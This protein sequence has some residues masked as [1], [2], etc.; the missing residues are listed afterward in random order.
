MDKSLKDIKLKDL[1]FVILYGVVVS[2]LLGVVI[3][4]IDYYLQRVISFSF[5]MIMFFISARFI[6]LRVRQQYEYPHIVYTII[7]GV[8]LVMQA[9]IIYALPTVYGLALAYNL[10]VTIIFDIGLYFQAFISIIT[11]FSFYGL[12]YILIVAVGTYQGIRVTY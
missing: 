11:N 7:T 10:D 6:G 1:L 9:V 3:G 5:S 12:L 4:L 8:F 2:L